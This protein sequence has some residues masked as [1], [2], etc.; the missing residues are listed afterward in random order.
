MSNNS[1]PIEDRIESELHH[2]LDFMD[3]KDTY[4]DDYKSMVG[5]FTKVMEI[6]QKASDSKNANAIKLQELQQQLSLSEATNAIKLQELQQQKILAEETHAIK[7]Q[8]LQQQRDLSDDT[9][10][11]KREELA[12]KNTIT[13]ET[14]LTVGTHIAGLVVL[15]N[16]ERA[17][18]IASKAFGLVRKIF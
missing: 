10:A 11:I 5:Q 12:L 18:V 16:H 15:M 13:K 6:R 1:T 7:L 4:D 8:E 17:H 9:N 2:L 3:D 14:W